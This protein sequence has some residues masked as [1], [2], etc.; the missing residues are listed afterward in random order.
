MFLNP[1][2][3]NVLSKL[4]N[5]KIFLWKVSE[6]S[7]HEQVPVVGVGKE[8]RKRGGGNKT[9]KIQHFPSTG[10]YLSGQLSY[11]FVD[12]WKNLLTSFSPVTHILCFGKVAS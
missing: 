6:Q 4:I 7:Y 11:S 8:E 5:K 2:F 12:K 9:E 10:L 1:L 3:W